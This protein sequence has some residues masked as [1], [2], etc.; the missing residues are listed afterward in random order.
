MSPGKA[1]MSQPGQQEQTLAHRGDP[2]ASVSNL[3][4]SGPVLGSKRALSGCKRVPFPKLCPCALLVC[5][6]RESP[7]PSSFSS[8][9]QQLL[10]APS[11]QAP[12][13][14]TNHPVSE[15][16]TRHSG[17][18]GH[19]GLGWAHSRHLTSIGLG[20]PQAGLWT[21]KVVGDVPGAGRDPL[22]MP[23][24]LC[25]WSHTP[26]GRLLATFAAR[27]QPTSHPHP[28]PEPLQHI[29][30]P[31]PGCLPSATSP[32]QGMLWHCPWPACGE[33]LP[34]PVSSLSKPP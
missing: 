21:A 26:A 14:A 4:R 10:P 12:S 19:W 34:T 20:E 30:L 11:A 29:C 18:L 6:S 31:A 3:A 16:P 17:S 28:G 8:P 27:V 2:T 33:F 23:R 9:R 1:A 7:V 25:S 15:P 22:S 32:A 13:L 24:W 5:A